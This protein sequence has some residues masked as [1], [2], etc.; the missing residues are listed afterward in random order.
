VESHS[1]DRQ[2]QTPVQ[3]PLLKD[4]G[5]LSIPTSV[6]TRAWTE[7]GWIEVDNA[8]A[9]FGDGACS[10]VLGSLVLDLRLRLTDPIA[11]STMADGTYPVELA[12]DRAGRLLAA[13]ICL[14][15]DVDELA[16]SWQPAG[17]VPITSGT[18][19]AADPFI[20]RDVYQ[21]SFESPTGLFPV[22]VYEWSDPEDGT[23]DWLGIRIRF[24][25]CSAEGGRADPDTT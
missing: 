9:S 18:C 16:G 22:E 19:I 21:R 14:T 12:H 15:T 25:R 6:G 5:D 3:A 4:V 1:R 17:A 11:F 24:H 10:K 20:A 23:V 13:R 8:T 7:S 2:L